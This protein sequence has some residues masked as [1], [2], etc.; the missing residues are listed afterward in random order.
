M[1]LELDDQIIQ[2]TG[3][4]QEQ[5]RVELAVQLY[6][7]GK[8]TVG[9]AGRMTSMGSIQFQQELGKRQIPSNY[10]KDDLDADL[11]TLSKLFQ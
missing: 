1:L 8:I 11:K 2:S 3:L 9:Q 7:Q 10:D 4:S 6:E 5:L